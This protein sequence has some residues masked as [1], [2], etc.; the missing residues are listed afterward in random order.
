MDGDVF[1]RAD[2]SARAAAEALWHAAHGGFFDPSHASGCLDQMFTSAGGLHAVPQ[3]S[4]ALRRLRREGRLAPIAREA[5]LE[6]IATAAYGPGC[7]Q[8]DRSLVQVAQCHVL[9]GELDT[10]VVLEAAFM[11]MLDGAVLTSRG[12]LL[13]TYGPEHLDAARRLLQPVAA[14]AASHVTRR[15][16]AKRLGLAKQHAV[17]LAPDADLRVGV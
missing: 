3:V 16:E 13:D 11:A 4:P 8:L 10:G 12:G 5:A 15:P 2:K 6:E 9:R 7:T 1:K 14:E 17:G